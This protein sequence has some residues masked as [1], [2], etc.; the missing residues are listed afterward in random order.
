MNWFPNKLFAEKWLEFIK[1]GNVID[2]TPPSES[3]YNVEVR[4]QG[5]GV[6]ISWQATADIES[7]I[8]GFRIYR[9]NN[10]INM[11]S[12]QSEWNFQIDY[13]D[14]PVEIH[15]RFEFAD[16]NINKKGEYKYQVSLIN[17]AGLE[18]AK[19]KVI[20]IEKK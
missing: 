13:H 18:S 19:S 12:S 14:N 1:T 20:V 2:S 6:V 5:Q 10:V 17:Q 3:P 15:D 7:G 8:K 16:R 9:N 11:D 4:K